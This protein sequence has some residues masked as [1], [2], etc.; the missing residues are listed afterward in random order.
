MNT[1][2]GS[3]LLTPALFKA[4]FSRKNKQAPTPDPLL[5]LSHGVF[6]DSDLNPPGFVKLRVIQELPNEE[7][8]ITI[9]KEDTA[10]TLST[11]VPVNDAR[12][13]AT[14]NDIIHQN[15]KLHSV[16]FKFIFYSGWMLAPNIYLWEIPPLA[17]PDAVESNIALFLPKGSRFQAEDDDEDIVMDRTFRVSADRQVAVN[18]RTVDGRS[19]STTVTEV[20]AARCATPGDYYVGIGAERLSVVYRVT[21]HADSNLKPSI[22]HTPLPA[23]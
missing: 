21:T 13:Y 6:H 2:A 15:G 11:I 5:F 3:H 19:Y 14:P 18:I 9:Y 23:V 20:E 1:L 12:F 7:A 17:A 4:R 22:Q 8:R 16:I 10:E